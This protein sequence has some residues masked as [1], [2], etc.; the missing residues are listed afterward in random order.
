MKSIVIIDHEPL[1]IRRKQ[2]FRIDE[3]LDAGFDVRF[4]DCSQFFHKGMQLADQIGDFQ[5]LL[6]L[7]DLREISQAIDEIGTENAVFIVEAFD[8]WENREFFRM[9]SDKK[10]YTIRMELYATANLPDVS[11]LQKL[12]RSSPAKLAH[13]VANRVRGKMYASY[14]QRYRIKNQDLFISS[15]SR[16][17]MNVHINHPDWEKY[18]A[19]AREE[20]HRAERY[21]VFLDEFF[22]LHPDLRFFIR[23]F[24]ADPEE[25]RRSML[26]FFDRFE[27]ST[28]LK[29]VIAA[30]P[31][32][33]Y[34]RDYWDGR[35]T[36]KYRTVDLVRNADAV[37]MHTSAALSFAVMFDKPLALI[38]T[39]GYRNIFPLD[40]NMQRIS[41]L[42]G[43]PIQDIEKQ[44][45]VL[46]RKL[47]KD[48]RENYI[49]TY[50]TSPGIED[51][52]TADILTDTFGHLCRVPGAER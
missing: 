17:D 2:I 16:A 19:C 44:T 23:N 29:I 41:N 37:L 12:L 34:N 31:K 26:G 46:I 51:K 1:T 36:V 52:L 15:G 48:V 38:R 40:I 21:T 13:V 33:D 28:G 6:H 39:Q 20:S 14:K 4:W 22:P 18:K 9:L 25:Y 32:S 10:C 5:G 49:Y 7:N 35:E 45:D 24:R 8:R 47:P 3:F 50:L 42:T 30:H 43:L 11:F 27:K